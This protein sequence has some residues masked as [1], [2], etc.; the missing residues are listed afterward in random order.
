MIIFKIWT[1]NICNN[2]RIYLGETRKKM[3]NTLDINKWTKI[4]RLK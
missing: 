4:I 2:K 3:Q 1:I